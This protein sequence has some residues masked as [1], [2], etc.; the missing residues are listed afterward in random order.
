MRSQLKKC[1]G[2]AWDAAYAGGI[3]AR[4]IR[5]RNHRYIAAYHR[6]VPPGVAEERW[7]ERPM[8]ISPESFAQNLDMF[9]TFGRVVPVEELLSTQRART[10][11][12][13]ITFDDGWLDNLEVAAPILKSRGIPA[14]L[15]VSTEAVFE[16]KPF[17]VNE[18]IH[19]AKAA[20]QSGRQHLLNEVSG[21]PVTTAIPEQIRLT[22]ERLKEVPEPER[23]AA[24]CKFIAAVQPPPYDIDQEMLKPE[25]LRSLELAGFSFGAHSHSHEILKGVTHERAWLE[26]TKPKQILEAFLGRTVSMFCY[27]NARFD[28]WVPAMAREAGYKYAF[29]IHNEP[30]PDADSAWTVPRY[31]IYEAVAHPGALIP[32]LLRMPGFV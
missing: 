18:F 29:K 10:P 19:A 16:R 23:R 28:P 20:A 12:F 13:A 22:V 5:L 21:A 4:L 2:L 17:W 11:L 1:V 31:S 9:Q 30:V 6:V 3:A 8:W 32:R 25:Q 7:I 27:P 24:L 14:T 26:L 15:F